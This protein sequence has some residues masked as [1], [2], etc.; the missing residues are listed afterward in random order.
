MDSESRQDTENPYILRLRR[1]QKTI[2]ALKSRLEVRGGHFYALMQLD[3]FPFAGLKSF[4]LRTLEMF[5]HTDETDGV[6]KL[7]DTEV[8]NCVLRVCDELLVRG[9]IGSDELVRLIVILDGN[10]TLKT[11]RPGA[12]SF[13]SRPMLVR[14]YRPQKRRAVAQSLASIPVCCFREIKRWSLA[15]SSSR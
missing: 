11:R 8:L 3:S 7:R 1:P 5:A 12:S 9:D 13:T 2:G 4:I 10:K 14:D 15:P 6:K